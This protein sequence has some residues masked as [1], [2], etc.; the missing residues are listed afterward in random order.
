MFRTK[1]Q[2][3]LT[4]RVPAPESLLSTPSM[5]ETRSAPWLWSMGMKRSI[6]RA[7]TSASSKARWWLNS[8]RPRCF[9]TMSSLCRLSSGSSRCESTRVS[10]TTG[11]NFIPLRSQAAAMK[12]VS[13]LALCAMIGRSP[14]KSRKARI[15]SASEGAPATSESRMPVSSVMFAGIGIFGSTKVLNL[16]RT[17]P[18]LKS[19]APISVSLSDTAE[20]PVVSTSK[21]TN[22]QS[23]RFVHFP[24]TAGR[25]ST[26]FT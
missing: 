8:G 14:T 1:R 10:S 4:F 5:S 18:P 2:M 16:S 20:R 26:S 7:T 23:S 24:R 19:T 22:S 9:E 17:S 13:K 3:C 25:S 11:S 21:A 15:A 12:P 6:I